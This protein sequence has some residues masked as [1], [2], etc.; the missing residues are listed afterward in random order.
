VFAVNS[1]SADRPH[2]AGRIAI[3]ATAAA[4]TQRKDVSFQVNALSRE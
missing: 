2:A 1:V 3:K 4:A